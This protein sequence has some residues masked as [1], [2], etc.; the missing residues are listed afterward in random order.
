MKAGTPHLHVDPCH[1]QSPISGQK[2]AKK[3]R[4]WMIILDI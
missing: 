3:Q 2:N 4:Q 1:D